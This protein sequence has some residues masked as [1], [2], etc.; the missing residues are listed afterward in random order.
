MTWKIKPLSGWRIGYFDPEDGCVCLDLGTP[1][2]NT[3]R[4][5]LDFLASE[6]GRAIN[7]GPHGL[8]FVYQVRTASG[9]NTR[10]FRSLSS[11]NRYQNQLLSRP[12]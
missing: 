12:A 8:I 10:Y 5:V 2:F 6:D 1:F 9:A 11:A 4:E 3:P 7:F